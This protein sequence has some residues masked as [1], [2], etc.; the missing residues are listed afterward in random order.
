MPRLS[1]SELE[2]IIV[3]RY[4][5]CAIDI[6]DDALFKMAYLARGLPYYA[7]LLGR[8][9]AL[10]AVEAGSRRISVDNVLG[11]L[12]EA[13]RNVDQTIT[14]L[15]LSAVRNQ[16]GDETLCMSQCFWHVL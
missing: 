15:Y 7:H 14:E 8:H 5:K 4:R 9:S 11:G 6:G 3:S 10:H 12:A 13:V 2:K 1:L 16:R